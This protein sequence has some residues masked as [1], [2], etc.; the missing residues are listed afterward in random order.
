MAKSQHSAFLHTFR[1][2]GKISSICRCC[3][4]MIAIKPNEIDLRQPESAHVC[5]DFSLAKLFH[6]Q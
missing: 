3:F 5:A 6:Q 4:V 1:A 2:D